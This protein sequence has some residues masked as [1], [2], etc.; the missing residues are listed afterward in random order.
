MCGRS[1]TCAAAARVKM[2]AIAEEA[3]E[4]VR[5][6]KGAFS[7]EHGDGLCRGEWIAWQFGPAIERGFPR[8]QAAS[9]IPIGLFNPG[10]ASSIRRAWTMR[11]LF[12]FPPPGHRILI[13][14]S[15]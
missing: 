12:R 2:R 15:R 11:A 13:R 10:N 9:W 14:C 4:L 6:Y 1:W 5:K 7:G 3:G 8:H